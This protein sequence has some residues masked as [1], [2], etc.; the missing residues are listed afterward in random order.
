M[1]SGISRRQWNQKVALKVPNATCPP[2][3]SILMVGGFRKLLVRRRKDL[4][5]RK[6]DWRVDIGHLEHDL[7]SA[8]SVG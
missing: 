5:F 3:D 1:T 8:S 4:C 2:S 6:F 7:D